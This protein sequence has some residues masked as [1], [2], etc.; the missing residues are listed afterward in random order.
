VDRWLNNDGLYDALP[1]GYKAI[2]TPFLL[3]RKNLNILVDWSGCC[4]WDE[5]CLRASL[6]C[7]G[8][9]I[10]FYQE[11]HENKMQQKPEVHRLF[12]QNLRK[13][14]PAECQV[15]IITDRGFQTSWF[16]MVKKMGWDF[17]GRAS[18]SYCYQINGTDEWQSIDKLYKNAISI[19]QYFGNGFIGKKSKTPVSFHLYKEVYKARKSKK[20][21]NKP[22]FSHLDKIYSKQH[23]TPW[24]IVTSHSVQNRSAKQIINNYYSRMQIEQ[25]FRD[26]KSERFGYGFRFGRTRSIKRLSILLFIAAICSFIL[27]IIGATAEQNKLHWSFQANS[28]KSRRVLSL[29]TLAKR[30]LRHCID[31][32]TRTQL[33]QGVAALMKEPQLCLI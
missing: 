13:I 26:D 23:T 11:I 25:N 2:F 4:N 19:P 33:T 32:I 6:V 18:Q 30:V 17:I 28:I 9:S 12:L 20:I 21:K 15:T 16:E 8:R 1:L 31:K 3:A 24:V 7:L 14:I 27:M 5:S 10:T 22:K 29:L